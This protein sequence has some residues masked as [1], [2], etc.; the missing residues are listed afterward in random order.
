[1]NIYK[2]KEP[3]RSAFGGLVWATGREAFPC[4]VMS[5]KAASL[6][7]T[8]VSFSDPSICASTS[9]FV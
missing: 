2:E 5:S 1:M 8:Q 4:S 3:F 6:L 7:S 9:F